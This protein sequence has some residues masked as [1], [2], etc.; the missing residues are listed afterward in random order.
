MFETITEYKFRIVVNI[1]ASDSILTSII[2]KHHINLK[3]DIRKIWHEASCFFKCLPCTSGNKN[4]TKKY[5]ARWFLYNWK[6]K[7]LCSWGLPF[8]HIQVLYCTIQNSHKIWK[9]ENNC[10]LL[11]ACVIV[12]IYLSACSTTLATLVQ[13]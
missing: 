10:L 7:M 2:L 3:E 11:S 13:V 1:C 8:E 4:R 12:A 9:Q 5:F 6:T